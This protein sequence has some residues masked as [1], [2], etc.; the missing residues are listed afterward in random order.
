M[1]R[2]LV[3]GVLE[4]ASSV[5][6]VYAAFLFGGLPWAVVVGSAVAFFWAWRL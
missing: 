3:S 4:V 2:Q 6:F 5:G 1:A